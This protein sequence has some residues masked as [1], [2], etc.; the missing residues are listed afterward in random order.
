MMDEDVK[1]RR[2]SAEFNTPSPSIVSAEDANTYLASA[3]VLRPIPPPAP[4]APPAPKVPTEQQR[5]ELTRGLKPLI[6]PSSFTGAGA[7]LQLVNLLDEFGISKVDTSTRLEIL[8]KIR[9]NAG[10]H[11]FRA[12][13]DNATAMEVIR[14]WLKLAFVGRTDAQMVETIMPI[15]HVSPD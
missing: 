7:V 8:T 11:Y 14:E 9:D 2:R 12:W 6:Q 10:N 5:A 13:V 3:F 1:F 15:L 4:P